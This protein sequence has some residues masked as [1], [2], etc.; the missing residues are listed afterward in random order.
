CSARVA[1]SARGVCASCTAS[2]GWRGGGV[3]PTLGRLNTPRT[4]PPSTSVDP[5]RRTFALFI[6]EHLLASLLGPSGPNGRI[7]V[8]LLLRRRQDGGQ[9]ER[10]DPQLAAPARRVA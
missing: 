6:L 7:Y 1:P 5:M 9:T 10:L 8:L 3:C 4:T 2:L